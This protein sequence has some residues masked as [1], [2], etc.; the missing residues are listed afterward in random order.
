VTS[1]ARQTSRDY[2]SRSRRRS[3]S[4]RCNHPP[5]DGFLVAARRG[6]VA[7]A[8][9]TERVGMHVRTFD[10]GCNR[11]VVILLVGPRVGRPSHWQPSAPPVRRPR[12]PEHRVD[13]R[14]VGFREGVREAP[15]GPVHRHGHRPER[16]GSDLRLSRDHRGHVRLRQAP[17]VSGGH[18]CK[19]A[20]K[21]RHFSSLRYTGQI[22]PN[23]NALTAGFDTTPVTFTSR[24]ATL[25][26]RRY[27]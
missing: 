24:H 15:V 19:A 13:H 10:P 5:G 25:P 3:V 12:E 6:R 7:A 27:R 16:A 9:T 18:T 8:G 14:A 22:A 20:G 26:L 21:V 23:T 1:R 2:G 11:A 17:L 4:C